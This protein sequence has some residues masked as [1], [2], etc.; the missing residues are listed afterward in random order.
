MGRNSSAGVAAES[1]WPVDMVPSAIC[2]SLGES[3]VESPCHCY[4]SPALRGVG[5]RSGPTRGALATR[6]RGVPR[7]PPSPSS[8]RA[9][10]WS[11]S[12]PKPAGSEKGVC[13]PA[14]SA[15]RGSACIS[16]PTRTGTGALR[17]ALRQVAGSFGS[18]ASAR[19]GAPTPRMGADPPRIGCSSA[20]AS[21]AAAGERHLGFRMQL[22]HLHRPRRR[23][24]APAALPAPARRATASPSPAPSARPASR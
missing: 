23:A 17:A 20:G 18:T 21:S 3:W 24:S 8:F 19:I 9:S 2:V 22:D 16:C 6:V 7:A 14:N 12:R 1:A 4:T 10:P 13:E 5:P 11:A 15:S